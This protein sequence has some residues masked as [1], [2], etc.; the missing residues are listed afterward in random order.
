[1]PRIGRYEILDELGRGFMGAV[2]KARDAQIGRA[3]AI[4]IILTAQ[5]PPEEIAQYR[6]RFRREAQAAGRMSHPGIVTIYDIAES[7]AGEPYIVMEYVEGSPLDRLFAPD[8]E[9]PPLGQ[10]LDWAQQVAEGLDY[11]HSRGVQP[12]VAAAF[13][14]LSLPGGPDQTIPMATIET[15]RY[16]SHG[17]FGSG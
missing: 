14:D 2:Y 4:K 11:A 17:L 3:V 6:E 13:A 16:V 5:L 12:R 1:M 10:V 15:G 8:A 9:R 7:E